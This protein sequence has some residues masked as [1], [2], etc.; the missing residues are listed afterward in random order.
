SVTIKATGL[1]YSLTNATV[2]DGEPLSTIIKAVANKKNV[3]LSHVY[4]EQTGFAAELIGAGEDIRLT[5]DAAMQVGKYKVSLYILAEDSAHEA[6]LD[7]LK[8]AIEGAT[9]DKAA[10]K[11]AYAA[12]MK[13]YG[14]AVTTTI[15]VKAKAT[16]AG[17]LKLA[18]TKAAFSADKYEADSYVVTIPYTQVV[19]KKVATVSFT[20][21]VKVQ[22]SDPDPVEVDLI[23]AEVADQSI[24]LTMEKE[25][26]LKAVAAGKAAYGKALKASLTVSFGEGT[27]EESYNLT[28]TMPKQAMTLLEAE[29]AVRKADLNGL[30]QVEIE[31]ALKEILSLD[32]AVTYRVDEGTKKDGDS[33]KG[34]D[35]SQEYVITLEENGD[36]KEIRV[37]K[38]IPATGKQPSSLITELQQ[39]ADAYQVANDTTV[40]EIGKAAREELKISDYPNLRLIVV[41]NSKVPATESDKGS[42]DVTYKIVDVKYGYDEQQLG[43]VYEIAILSPAP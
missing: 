19:D 18:S 26:L 17:K 14:T 27:K 7:A 10:E 16:T 38:V 20:N 33:E 1:K 34:I 36:S 15:T 42:L 4:T 23:T 25:N 22:N 41:E 5:S 30:D 9:G 43:K 24:K 11:A 32:T 37:V 8:Q 31:D 39:F 21:M 13:Q 12:A 35:G 6:K 28:V 29:A 40:E 3:T 2:L